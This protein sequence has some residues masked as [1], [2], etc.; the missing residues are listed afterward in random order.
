MKWL[1]TVVLSATGLFGQGL[2]DD[3][4]R[5]AI[6]ASQKG[7]TAKAEF[8]YRQMRLEAPKDERWATGLL[9]LMLAQG[10]GQDGLKSA[11]E[12]GLQFPK[13]ATVH[14]QVGS[15]LLRSDRETEALKEFESGLQY[16][17]DEGLKA[18]A[19]M[20][21]GVAH[22]Q[23]D[24]LDASIAAYRQAK[25]ITGRANVSLAIVLGER[26]KIEEE[27]A[28]YRAVLREDP[29]LPVALNNLAYVWAERGENLDQ[30]YG[31]ALRAVAVMPGDS[32]LVDTLAWVYFRKGMFAEAEETQ[33]D[34]LL[35][36][37]GNH[38]TLREHM[39]AVM[40]ARGQWTAERRELRKLLE[41]ELSPSQ[42]ARLKDLLRKAQGDKR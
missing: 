17:D 9:A 25:A 5:D 22:R 4:Y 40:D 38:P 15:L 20:L 8:L 31:M 10:R 33:L 39:A 6:E 36:E 35:R 27:I 23:M 37:G 3:L 24:D 28:E 13:S 7:D 21:I 12:I 30:A 2:V 42:V 14:L 26:G 41:G 16:A 32:N 29:D 11:K 1:V 18:T 34:A 19:Y